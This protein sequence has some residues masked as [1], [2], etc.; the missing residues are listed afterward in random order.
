[1][2]GIRSL[3][4]KTNDSEANTPS[5]F[6]TRLSAL[7]RMLSGLSSS[8]DLA[9]AVRGQKKK[10]GEGGGGKERERRKRDLAKYDCVGHTLT[11]HAP[12]LTCFCMCTVFSKFKA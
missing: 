11:A 4:F 12:N 9:L 1:M 10:T 3:L 6:W 2:N 5:T 7:G 8:P